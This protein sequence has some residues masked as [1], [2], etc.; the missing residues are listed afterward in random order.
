MKIH[1]ITALFEGYPQAQAAF[2]QAGADS[3]TV[4]KTIADFRQLV[5]RNQIKDLNQKNIDWWAKQ[6]W[7]KFS[8]FVNQAAAI[9]SKTQVKRKKL[10]GQSIT[11]RDDANWF[12]VVPLDKEASCF[13][14]KNSHWCTT[15]TNQ[16]EFE[17]L[18]YDDQQTLIYCF[19]KS[20]GGMWAIAVPEEYELRQYGPEIHTQD[21]DILSP[22]SF[23]AKTGLNVRELTDMVEILHPKI[24]AARDQWED[25]RS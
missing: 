11:L 13:H 3:Q 18:F 16:S 24:Q 25:T 10:L 15:K 21:Q 14:G 6:G 9:P 4:Q 19:N 17:E 5:N 12:I 8:Q 22:T 23:K 1:E 7:D 2:V 20:S